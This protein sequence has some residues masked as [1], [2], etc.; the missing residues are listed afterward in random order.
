MAPLVCRYG[1]DP[2]AL[3]ESARAQTAM[4]HNNPLVTGGAELIARATCLVLEGAAPTAALMETA[5]RNFS[6]SPLA[7]WVSDGV[8]SASL[9]TRQAILDFGQMCEI[10]AAFPATVHLVAKYETDLKEALVENVMAGGDSS[11]RGM[12]VGMLL[13]AY[14]G[15]TAIPDDWLTGLK[16]GKEINGLLDS[17]H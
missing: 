11:S 6:G 16:C 7:E 13:G 4:T 10:D 14:H 1:N 2:D 17:I 5:A 12:V 8:E 3:A 9:E 15:A